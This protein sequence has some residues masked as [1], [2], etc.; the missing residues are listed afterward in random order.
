MGLGLRRLAQA[1]A[2][3]LLLASSGMAGEL[4]GFGELDVKDLAASTVVI[5]S[6]TYVVTDRSVIRDPKGVRMGLAE[7][8]IPHAHEDVNLRPL[9]TGRFDAQEVRGR[10]VLL[11]LDL[12]DAPH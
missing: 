1:T 12:V 10:L 7:L 9:V 3:G 2:L 11:S 8:P 5:G 6:R 4:K